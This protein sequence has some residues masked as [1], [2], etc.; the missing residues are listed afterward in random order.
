M[1]L[2]NT[3]EGSVSSGLGC[4]AISFSIT[5]S[6]DSEIDKLKYFEKQFKSKADKE[7]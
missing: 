3:I 4:S 6:K 5:N 2:T 7:N 1:F